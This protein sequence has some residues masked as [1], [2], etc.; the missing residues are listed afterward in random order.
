[1]KESPII[2]DGDGDTVGG[3]AASGGR[4]HQ[5][6]EVAEAGYATH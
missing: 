4:G 5:H 6:M 2:D 1:M 3:I